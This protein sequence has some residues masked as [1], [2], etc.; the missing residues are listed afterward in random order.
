MSAPTHDDRGPRRDDTST[1]DEAREH[2]AGT[3]GHDALGDTFEDDDDDDHDHGGP[4]DDADEGAAADEEGEGPSLVDE[5]QFADADDAGDDDDDVPMHFSAVAHPEAEE[6]LPPQPES[7]EPPEIPNDLIDADALW[8]VRRLQAKGFEAYLT[9]GCVRDLL[10]GRTPKDF[11]V[12]TAAHPNQVKSVFR[13]CRLVGRRFRLAHVFFPSGKVIE[14]ATFRANPIDE[15]DDLPS[16]LLVSRD[17]VFGTVEQDARR[18]DL[19]I[20]GLFYDPLKGKVLDFVDGRADLE[21][22][23]IRTIG[24]PEVRFQEDPVRIIRAIKFATRLGFSIEQQTLAGMRAAVGGLV[25]CAP[26]RLQEELLRLLT[27]GHAANALDL[28]AAVGVGAAIMPELEAA[29]DVPLEPRPVV[30]ALPEAIAA[31][32][33][34][35]GPEPP[36]E[37]SAV[38]DAEPPAPIAVPETLTVPLPTPAER[39]ARAKKLL[40]ALDAA[41]GRDLDIT[42][43]MAFSVLIAPVWEAM[44]PSTTPF[45][46]W[47][48]DTLQAWSERLRLTRHDKERVPQ[49]LD[50]QDDLVAHKRRGQ[51]GRSVTH[52]PSFRESLLLLTLRRWASDEPL[53]EIGLWKVMAASASAPYQQPRLS[54]RAPRMR[55][56]THVGGSDRGGGRRR[57]RG[58][59]RR[60][61]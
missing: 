27:S 28:C 30:V 4:D 22:R 56:A 13:N 43:A 35:V 50:G 21:A 12:A 19:T 11:D 58:G 37:P 47:L 16:D 48:A 53:D 45:D 2:E 1:D 38:G 3:A 7:S 60:R 29:F 17:N 14:T 34:A 39:R 49:I 18:R 40:E 26:A 24:T 25:R 5:S 15:L 59:R 44:K 20:N 32:E 6:P 57:D 61:R 10:L 9:G 36:N 23:L 41:R 33:P 46:A 51:V 55:A 8:V 42:S 54:E 52:R 31:T